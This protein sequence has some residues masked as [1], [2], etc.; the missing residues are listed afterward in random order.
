MRARL[1]ALTLSAVVAAT[2][3]ACGSTEQALRA[4][5]AETATSGGT[6]V[7]N[8]ADDLPG[9]SAC[10]QDGMFTLLSGLVEAVNAHDPAAVSEIFTSDARWSVYDHFG[11]NA[12]V[13]SAALG[14]FATE[15]GQRGDRWT[16]TGIEPPEEDL[17]ATPP[18]A[19]SVV[20]VTVTAAGRTLERRAKV[21]VDCSSG[22]LERM[23]GPHSIG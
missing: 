6:T 13:G 18:V 10:R 5:A 11:S 14:G 2:T 3:A 9:L 7:E 19:T 12:L 15:V 17:D 8:P 23:A 4:E 20:R 1:L 21:T 16:L 22:R